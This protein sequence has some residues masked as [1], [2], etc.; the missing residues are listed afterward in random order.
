MTGPCAVPA[1]FQTFLALDFGLVRTGVATGNR[2]LR[3]ATPQ[4]T[5]AARGDARFV[6]LAQRIAHWQPDALV[7]GVPYHPDGASHEN[8]GR[9]LRFG[10][11]LRG[12]FGLQVFEVDERY[13][14]TEALAG[15]ARDA[16][17]A[18]ACII[19]EQFLRGLA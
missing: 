12:R 17:A 7:I 4:P 16:D 8:T 13:S 19:L 15:G 1:H 11:R 14:T 5:I 6:H 9:A 3:S 18:S 10:R 2:L